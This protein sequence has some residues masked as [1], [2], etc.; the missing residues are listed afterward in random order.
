MTTLRKALPPPPFLIALGSAVSAEPIGE[1]DTAFQLMGPDHKVVVD[2]F[3][4]PRVA[5]VTCYL[6]RA[7]TG[8]IKGAIGLAEDK[9]ESSVACRQV[10]ACRSR[11]PLPL[12]EEMFNERISLV[13]KRLRVVR[14]VD[15]AQRAG[16]SDLLRPLVDGSPKNSVSVVPIDRA[17]PIPAAL[18][19]RF[20]AA[21]RGAHAR[22]A[23]RP[24][25]SAAASRAAS[26]T[27][28]VKVMNAVPPRASRTELDLTP[29]TFIFSLAKH[30]GDIAQQPLPVARLDA[31]VDRIERRPSPRRSRPRR[32][33]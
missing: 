1:V 30:L 6:S 25:P 22:H 29:M 4:D 3:D 23:G 24:V 27:S 11:R 7:K 17:T 19:A 18:T 5:G 32:P 31:D 33:G 16:L 8:G 15:R 21:A 26:A 9:S 2:A 28:T 20:S 13:F 14:M 12:R 10:G